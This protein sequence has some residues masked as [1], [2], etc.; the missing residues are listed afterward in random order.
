MRRR[1]SL[2][3]TD[4]LRLWPRAEEP[5]TARAAEDRGSTGLVLDRRVTDSPLR[6]WLTLFSQYAAFNARTALGRSSA[7]R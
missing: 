3:T 5:I 1:T 7:G 2:S 4:H 6:T